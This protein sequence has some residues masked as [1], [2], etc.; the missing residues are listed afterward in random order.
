MFLHLS[1]SHSVHG[2]GVVGMACPVP[3]HSQGGWVYLVPNPFWGICLVTGSFWERL[4]IPGTRSLLGGWKGTL[5]SADILVVATG[6]RRYA[7]YWNALF[8]DLIHVIL[9]GSFFL[10]VLVDTEKVFVTM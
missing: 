1:L 2:V 3:G 4:G 10:R 7:F 9:K 8:Y 5:P 6:S